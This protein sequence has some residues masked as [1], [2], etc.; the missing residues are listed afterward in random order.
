MAKY[1]FK[2]VDN[3][4]FVWKIETETTDPYK[5][6]ETTFRHFVCNERQF[7]PYL[8]QTVEDIKNRNLLNNYKEI[9]QQVLTD[10]NYYLDKTIGLLHKDKYWNTLFAVR[11]IKCLD[12]MSPIIFRSSIEDIDSKVYDKLMTCDS[13]VGQKIF[14]TAFV[15]FKSLWEIDEYFSSTNLDTIDK[16]LKTIE[17]QAVY[18]RRDDNISENIIHF[19]FRPSWDEEH[20]L[21]IILNLENFEVTVN[22]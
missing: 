13:T 21:G 5:L 7:V 14:D 3:I 10:D 17:L 16:F 20:G 15:Y 22:K 2:I 6:N 8:F 1:F 12:R 4:D 11:H 19:A 9:L 18:I